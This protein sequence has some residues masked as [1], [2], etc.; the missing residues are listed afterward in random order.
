MR[1]RG[2]PVTAYTGLGQVQ[3][4]IDAVRDEAERFSPN[5]ERSAGRGPSLHEAYGEAL[6]SY[7]SHEVAD[8]LM[9]FLKGQPEEVRKAAIVYL[10]EMPDSPKPSAPR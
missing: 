10:T 5:A 9:E 4:F 3:A 1:R 8:A 7:G 2:F 6:A